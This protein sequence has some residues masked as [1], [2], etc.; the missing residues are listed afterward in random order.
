MKK[1]R[2]IIALFAT[3][4]YVMFP[5]AAAWSETGSTLSNPVNLRLSTSTM[6][7]GWYTMGGALSTLLMK[8]MPKGSQVA[9]TPGPG[10]VGNPG[11]ISK[12]ECE[13]AWAGDTISKFAYDG[14][15]LYKEPM[16]NIRML[17]NGVGPTPLLVAMEKKVAEKEGV[18]YFDDIF[19]KKIPLT[20]V[21]GS[22]GSMDET[23]LKILLEEMGY[24]G[25]ADLKKK[26]GI[27]TY[28]YPKDQ[29]RIEA[30]T[31]GR[32][33]VFVDVCTLNHPTWTQLGSIKALFYLPIS[34]DLRNKLV[35]HYGFSKFTW[36][37]GM[38]KGL[39][40]LNS[41]Q[42]ATCLIC[43]EN[44]PEEVAYEVV[45]IMTENEQELK[46]LHNGFTTFDPEKSH[47]SPLKLHEGAAR[48]YKEV[49][50]F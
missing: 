13:L 30:F 18:K 48:Y 33:Q 28:F 23:F 6:G 35:E 24:K 34:E 42:Y 44:L 31:A 21:S 20:I 16:S 3:I 43:N 1:N 7:G 17:V 19:T 39:P 47:V 40:D 38:Y 25:Y 9:M 37:A 12:G 41:I 11:V 22:R 32:A 46:K 15:I 29:D 14:V 27:S 26:T 2:I 4:I 50:R 10:T 5:L 45:K 49:G 36:P 8:Y